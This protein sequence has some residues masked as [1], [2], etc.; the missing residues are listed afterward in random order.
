MLLAINYDF[1]FDRGLVGFDNSGLI[2]VHPKANVSGLKLLG[3]NE[4]V[5][6]VGEMNKK[7]QDYL[8][9]HRQFVFGSF[10]DQSND[11]EPIEMGVE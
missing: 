6:L 9:Y 5:R 11:V 7:Q 2:S 4:G 3:I 10:S 8:F 1:A